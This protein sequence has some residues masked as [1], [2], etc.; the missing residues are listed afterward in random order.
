LCFDLLPAALCYSDG[1]FEVFRPAEA[2]RCTDGGEIWHGGVDCSVGP[3]LLAKF[4]PISATI[5]V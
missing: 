5:R 3:L 1:N 2:I 4:H